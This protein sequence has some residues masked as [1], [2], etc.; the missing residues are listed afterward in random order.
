MAAARTLALTR[1]VVT[2]APVLRDILWMAT[3]KLAGT[4]MNAP[5]LIWFRAGSLELVLICPALTVA[6]ARLV[7]RKLAT[8]VLV[9]KIDFSLIK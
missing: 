5:I 6:S 8:A 7:M 4:L 2:N 9:T 3:G 1:P